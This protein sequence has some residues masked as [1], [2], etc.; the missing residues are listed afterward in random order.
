MIYKYAILV[1]E[2]SS[3]V[4]WYK[5]W[6]A[7][8]FDIWLFSEFIIQVTWIF[9]Q[10]TGPVQTNWTSIPFS[11]RLEQ[12]SCTS[13]SIALSVFMTTSSKGLTRV[14]GAAGIRWKRFIMAEQIL[15]S[16]R[17][18]QRNASQWLLV[19]TSSGR[20]SLPP[21]TYNQQWQVGEHLRESQS[22]RLVPEK[23]SQNHWGIIRYQVWEGPPQKCKT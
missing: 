7:I 10:L 18:E 9:D 11:C 1:F 16:C 15:I 21:V 12:K 5:Y 19:I 3:F 13:M 17:G 4:G 2:E 22:G 20:P 6:Y 23:T 14:C 8:S